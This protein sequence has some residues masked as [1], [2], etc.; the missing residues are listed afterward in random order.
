[1]YFSVI[2]PVY[3]RPDDLEDL[4][5]CLVAQTF[6]DFEVI[7]VESGST[8]PS[9]EV[10]ARFTNQLSIQHLMAGND[11]Q[12]FSRNVGMKHA[13]GAFFVIL[14]SDLFLPETYLENVKEGI[15]RDNL[16]CFGGP[17]RA[18]ASFTPMQKAI[19]YA[20][21]SPLTTGGIRGGKK[22]VGKFYPRSFNMGFSRAVYND[23]QGYKYPFFGEDIELSRR[24]M[25]LGYTTGL[26]H[27]AYVYHKRKK[28][29]KGAFMQ[30]EFFGRARIQIYKLFP[31]TLKAT[32]FFPALFVLFC[33]SIPV[34][35]LINPC[36]GQ[37]HAGALLFYVILNF[38]FAFARYKSPTIAFYS[39]GA[40]FAQLFGY[41][42]GF[43][44]D[45]IRRLILKQEPYFKNKDNEDR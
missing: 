4:L 15:E 17:D 1:M 31:D 16:D 40:I 26:I 13:K 22:H 3:N 7:I 32:H 41:G 14:D 20:M 45:F 2:I 38:L 25:S 34:S 36:L 5:P 11:G 43:I 6:R 19:D 8:E 42:T 30:T 44:K 9:D 10:I 23:T 33:L 21:T 35:F 29:L 39:I 18:H 28:S 12:G 27:E 24:I 37:L